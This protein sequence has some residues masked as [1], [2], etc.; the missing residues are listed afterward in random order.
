M[1]NSRRKP[2]LALFA[3]FVCTDPTLLWT[4]AYN[5]IVPCTASTDIL[6]VI[7]IDI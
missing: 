7:E 3:L 6:P 5:S 4:S 2:T 1:I